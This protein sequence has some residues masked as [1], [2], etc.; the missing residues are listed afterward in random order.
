MTPLPLLV[1][2]LGLA[3]LGW[4]SARARALALAGPGAARLHSLP[5]Y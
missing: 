5:G 3:L 1:T 2:I 4:L